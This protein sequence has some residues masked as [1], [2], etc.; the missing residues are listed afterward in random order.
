MTNNEEKSII[1]ITFSK[2][3]YPKEAV[4]KAAYSYI[5]KCYVYLTHTETDYSVELTAK[6]S[7]A[8][9][10]IE[11]EFKNELL[12]QTARFY[13]Y[14]QTHTIREILIARAMA[15][16]IIDEQPD[17]EAEKQDTNLD[18][19]VMDWFDRYEQEY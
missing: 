3:L 4:I 7:D 10:N 8:F 5:D 19:I 9:E 16:T 1:K 17:L 15:S 11:N 12:A 14:K 6:E 2:D 18:G 13:V